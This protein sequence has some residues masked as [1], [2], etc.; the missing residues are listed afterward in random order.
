MAFVATM[1]R[2]YG[3]PFARVSAAVGR[4][5]CSPKAPVSCSPADADRLEGRTARGDRHLVSRAIEEGC[6]GAADGAHSDHSHPHVPILGAVA[7]RDGPRRTDEQARGARMHASTRPVSCGGAPCR[8]VREFG[9]ARTIRFRRHRRHPGRRSHR[10]PERHPAR[11]QAER[12]DQPRCGL[13]GA[14]SGRHPQGGPRGHPR[15]DGDRAPRARPRPC[16]APAHPSGRDRQGLPR[17]HPTRTGDDD[18]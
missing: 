2:S 14:P 7:G 8:C 6:E 17:H 11:R 15:S 3:T 12:T 5:R 10:C 9:H 13:A 16:D 1:T 4:A 18:G